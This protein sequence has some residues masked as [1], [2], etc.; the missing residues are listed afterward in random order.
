MRFLAKLY[1]SL[2]KLVTNPAQWFGQRNWLVRYL[3]MTLLIPPH[4]NHESA[5]LH[6]VYRHLN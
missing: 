3:V 1:L 6:H 5:H 4:L 2:E